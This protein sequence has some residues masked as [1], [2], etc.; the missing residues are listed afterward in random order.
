METLLHIYALP[1]QYGIELSEVLF[2]D[3]C[4]IKVEIINCI[5]NASILNT[6]AKYY[7]TH[8]ADLKHI[9]LIYV[10]K[11]RCL[12]KRFVLSVNSCR[13]T[14]KQKWDIEERLY[15]KIS[16]MWNQNDS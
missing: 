8:L 16:A 10:F 15:Q 9:R 13:R 5:I 2:I 14:Q 7:E 6:F 1:W 3:E 11:L 4:W 12:V